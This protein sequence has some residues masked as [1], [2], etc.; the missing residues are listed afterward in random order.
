ME[1]GYKNL[2]ELLDKSADKYA[3]RAVLIFHDEDLTV[4]YSDFRKRVN[5]LAN[6][7]HRMGIEKRDRVGVMLPNIIDFPTAWFA[8]AKNGAIMVPINNSYMSHDLEYVINDSEA[9]LVIIHQD[10]YETLISVKDNCTGLKEV[11]FLGTDPPS[12]TK[13][14]FKL[15]E[16]ADDNFMGPNVFLDDLVNIQYTSGTTGFPK[17]CMLTHKY[18]LQLGVIISKS[19]EVSSDDRDLQAQPFYY[20]DGQWNLVTCMMHGITLVLMK[21]FSSSRHWKVCKERE[22]TFFYCLG[23][24]PRMLMNRPEDPENEKGHKVKFVICSG[25]DP[26]L[27]AIF[28][29]RWNCPWYEAYGLT[30][31]GSDLLVPR[32]DTTYTGSGSIGKPSLWKEVAVIDENGQALPP[33]EIGEIVSRGEPMMIG[34]WKKPEATKERF[35]DGWF[36]TGDLG[37][38]GEDGRFYF[39]GRKKDMVRRSNENISAAEVE[40]VLMAHPKIELAAVIPVPDPVRE[41]EVKAYVVLTRGETKERVPPLEIIS[42]AR[43]RL[44]AFKVPRYIEYREDLPKTPS[45]RVEKEKLIGEKRDLRSDSYDNQDDVWR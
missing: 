40:G 7:L 43:E 26:K 27:H 4:I 11:L 1:L 28:E 2:G 29:K 6:V 23:A 21:R 18:W 17:G 38:V 14:Y 33:G 31:T 22:V 44:A 30:E 25:I 42:F 20:M 9:K 19:Y 5:R 10:Y 41:E 24:M 8:I 12:G 35:K 16:E 13:D 39:V 45:E 36:S 34:Y 32:R 37:Y 3:E 15:L